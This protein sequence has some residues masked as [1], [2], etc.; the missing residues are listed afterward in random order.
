LLCLIVIA[1]A[2]LASVC[3]VSEEVCSPPAATPKRFELAHH[4]PD[5]AVKMKQKHA[6]KQTEKQ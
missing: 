5:V 6:V 4:S 3:A 1:S 2:L